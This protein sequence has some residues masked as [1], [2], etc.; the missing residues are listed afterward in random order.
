MKQL[1]SLL[2]AIRVRAILTAFLVGVV[3]LA[4]LVFGYGQPL[5]A[6]AAKALT[7]EVKSYQS[8]QVKSDRDESATRSSNS[9]ADSQRDLYNQ[10][11]LQENSKNKLQ[12]AADNVREKLNLDEPLPPSTKKFINQ[13]QDDNPTNALTGRD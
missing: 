11:S 4:D 9:Q 13:L 7:P 12:E 8:G 5:P 2:P 10:D 3:L 6:H 1:I